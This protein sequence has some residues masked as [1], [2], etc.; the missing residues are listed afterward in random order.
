MKGISKQLLQAVAI[1]V[2]GLGLGI[3]ANQLKTNPPSVL[4]RPM[5]TQTW[6]EK[7]IQLTNVEQ[8]TMSGDFTQEYQRALEEEKITPKPLPIIVTLDVPASMAGD[9]LAP[10][11]TISGGP[12]EGSTIAYTNPC[13]PLWV[14]DNMTP[15]QQ[16]VTRNKL[17]SGQWSGWMNIFSYCF[18]NLGDGNHTVSV[19]IK[20]LAGNISSEVKRTFVVKR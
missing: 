14:N 11:V 16:L 2:A 1:I 15:W 3:I 10:S 19:Q 12:S 8:A 5:P 18:T 17:D 4:S 9:I 7:T 6:R 13:F 20:D